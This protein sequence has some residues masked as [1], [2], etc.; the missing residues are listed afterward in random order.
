M[1]TFKHM[2]GLL[3]Q[4]TDYHARGDIASGN[5][6][7]AQFKLNLAVMTDQGISEIATELSARTSVLDKESI[8]DLIFDSI[9]EITGTAGDWLPQL[10]KN[11]ADFLPRN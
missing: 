3:V 6:L 5:R 9:D 1:E 10:T 7:I 2:T 4:A 8:E 11:P